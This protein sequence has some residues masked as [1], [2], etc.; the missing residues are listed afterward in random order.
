MEDKE[1]RRK[2]SNHTWDSLTT[3]YVGPH[4]IL[5]L[6]LNGAKRFER[7]MFSMWLR[8]ED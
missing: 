8:G 2:W 5:P 4:V 3:R 1:Q 6:T 7:G